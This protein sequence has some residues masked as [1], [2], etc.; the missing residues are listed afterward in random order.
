MPIRKQMDR[1]DRPST[2]TDYLKQSDIEQID[3]DMFLQL[4]KFYDQQPNLARKSTADK[5]VCKFKKLQRTN[6]TGS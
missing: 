5:Q 2:R 4:A 3:C 1:R 6:T